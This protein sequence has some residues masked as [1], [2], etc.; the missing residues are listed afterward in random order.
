MQLYLVNTSHFKRLIHD[1]LAVRRGD[2]REWRLHAETD[3]NY[4]RQILSESLV[5]TSRGG[6]LVQEWQVTDKTAGNHYL[7]AEVLAAA[8]AWYPVAVHRYE[9]VEVVTDYFSKMRRSQ[10]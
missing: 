8:A 5:T 6:R 10:S 9:P 7:D 1:R 4:C 3:A 2:P